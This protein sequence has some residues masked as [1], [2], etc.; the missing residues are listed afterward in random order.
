MIIQGISWLLYSLFN[1]DYTSYYHQFP[2]QPFQQAQ[3]FFSQYNADR[4]YTNIFIAVGRG[5]AT[6]IGLLP[7]PIVYMLSIGFTV[8]LVSLIIR[9]ILEVI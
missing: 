9:I 5:I 7:V 6:I 3:E 2:D 1:S 4:Q 8:L